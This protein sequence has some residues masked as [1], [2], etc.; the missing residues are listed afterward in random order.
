MTVYKFAN[1]ASGYLA[2]SIN[3]AD[4][5]LTTSTTAAEKFPT[6]TTSEAFYVQISEGSD[7]EWV[8]CASH[9]ASSTQLGNL[10]RG[11]EGTSAQAF[12]TSAKVELML[13][14]TVLNAFFQKGEYITV[15]TAPTSV[16][17]Y[18]GAEALDTANS[19][20]YKAYSTGS[21]TGWDNLN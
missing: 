14:A 15:T 9:A 7:Y 13:P 17:E 6:L 18:I 3:A 5:S 20:W 4:T 12:T 21:A 2:A 10:T 16:P 19:V 1:N 11:E 8:L